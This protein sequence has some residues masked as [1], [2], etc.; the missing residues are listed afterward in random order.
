MAHVAP[1]R[2]KIPTENPQPPRPGATE[3]AREDSA[4]P[5]VAPSRRAERNRARGYTQ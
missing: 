5:E 3:A 1:A 2:A 4:G